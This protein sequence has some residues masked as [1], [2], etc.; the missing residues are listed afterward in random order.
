MTEKK[1]DAAKETTELEAYMARMEFATA[2]AWRPEPGQTLMGTVAGFGEGIPS[3]PK[4]SKYNIVYVKTPNQGMFA[5]HCFHTLLNEGFKNINVAKGMRVGVT[6]VDHRMK[7]DSIGKPEKDLEA[8]DYY[9]YYFVANMDAVANG[10]DAPEE[11]AE[12][13]FS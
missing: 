4:L 13:D 1:F 3:D 2:P 5:L 12:F 6:F 7:N 9:Y 8:T 11:G 10:E